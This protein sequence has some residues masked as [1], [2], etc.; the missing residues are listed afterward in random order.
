MVPGQQGRKGRDLNSEGQTSEG[1]QLR[2]ANEQR[3]SAPR[4]TPR[5]GTSAVASQLSHLSC[6][7]SALTPVL[8][9]VSVMRRTRCVAAAGPAQLL[10]RAP[11]PC[12]DKVREVPFALPLA[13][14]WPEA[15]GRRPVEWEGARGPPS[16][17]AP[18]P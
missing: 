13:T 3:D 8:E 6:G 4:G 15:P 9:R 1:V 16:E 7:T 5:C 2:G 11:I 17:S 18:Q 12:R 14:Q 10:A